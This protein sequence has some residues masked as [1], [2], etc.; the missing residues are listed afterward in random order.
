MWAS[1]M[2]GVAD[3]A[4]LPMRMLFTSPVVAEKLTA[5]TMN[6]AVKEMQYAVRGA[7]VARAAEIER[8]LQK[9]P[10]SFP[11]DTVIYC[12]IGNP[13]S[14]GQAPITFNRQVLALV[15][16]PFLLESPHCN[17]MFP[18]DAIARA[19]FYLSSTH[20]IGA[21]SASQG[22]EVV[23]NEVAK[24][25]EHRDNSGPC[26]PKNIF[27]TSGASEGVKVILSLLRKR[28]GCLIP[29]PQYPLYSAALTLLGMNP[30]HYFLDESKQWSCNIENIEKQ[31]ETARHAGIKPRAMAVINPGNPTGQVLDVDTMRAIVQLCE[32]E[33]ILLMADE[34]YQTNIYLQKPFVSFR[35]VALELK[36]HCQIASFHSTSKGMIGECGLRGGYMELLNFNQDIFDQIIKSVSVNL[37]SNLPG[38]FMVG[39][40][41]NPPKKGDPSYDL[42]KKEYDGI[43]NSLKSKAAMLATALNTLPGISCNASEGAM[44][45]FPRIHLPPKAVEAAKQKNMAPDVLYCME[46]LNSTGTCVVPGSGFGQ[47]DGTF[48]FRTTFLPTEPL[49]EKSVSLLREFHVNFMKQYE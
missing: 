11:F 22:I 43:Y 40:M 48:H 46:L 44:Y 23:R 37:C 16:A 7:I 31:I 24:Y 13:Q 8:E 33:E 34:V 4:A 38:Q 28:D 36:S 49:I 27:L 41:C 20:G 9:K 3:L 1:V 19:K 21:Y 2:R 45:L 42:F 17:S 32:K 15:A 35:K 26:D 30:V 47:E 6:P 10:E 25:I 29:I 39:L 18:E 5:A 14:V 12:N